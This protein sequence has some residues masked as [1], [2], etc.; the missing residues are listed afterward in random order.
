MT[1]QIGR[2]EFEAS[3]NIISLVSSARKH[4]TYCRQH[5]TE[6]LVHPGTFWL[7]MPTDNMPT[8]HPTDFGGNPEGRHEKSQITAVLEH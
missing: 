3:I 4:H 8:G 7:V 5:N 2:I 6:L 1:P